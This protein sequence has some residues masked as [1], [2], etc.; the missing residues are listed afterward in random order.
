MS[1]QIPSSSSSCSSSSCS[2]NSNAITLTYTCLHTRI[3]RIQEVT[4]AAYHEDPFKASINEAGEV[5]LFA[6]FGQGDDFLTTMHLA[7]MQS[8]ESERMCDACTSNL[9]ADE[10]EGL[11]EADDTKGVEDRIVVEEGW[12]L[13]EAE[14]GEVLFDIEEEMDLMEKGVAG[15]MENEEEKVE[16]WWDVLDLEAYDADAEM[17]SDEEEGKKVVEMVELV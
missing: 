11:N 12:E 10:R 15:L 17:M 1:T 8:G 13:L 2:S 5:T 16:G 6:P 3:F 9:G 14:K 4:P 7:M